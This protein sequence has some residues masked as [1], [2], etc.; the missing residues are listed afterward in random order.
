[1]QAVA[2]VVRNRAQKWG[3]S[4]YSQ[5]VAANQFSSLVIKGDPNTVRWPPTTSATW[6]QA[7]DIAK[8]VVEGT[9]KDVTNG[10]LYYWNAK[11]ATSGWFKVNIAGNPESHPLISTIGD[12]EFYA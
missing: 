12:H 4:I 2:C 9:L 8:G 10:A 11:I 1:M 5:C 7:Q 3:G 6:Q